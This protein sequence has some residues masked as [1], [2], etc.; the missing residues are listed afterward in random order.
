MA[1]IKAVRADWGVVTSWCECAG[2][3]VLSD[4][5][6]GSGALPLRHDQRAA[7]KA[8]L[9]LDYILGRRDPRKP[10][11]AVQVARVLDHVARRAGVKVRLTGHSARVG[12]GVEMA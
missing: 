1:T 8:T 4:G 5:R 9:G 3:C 11:L 12:S 7:K 10:M 6:T 2:R